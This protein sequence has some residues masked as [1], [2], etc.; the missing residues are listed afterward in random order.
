MQKNIFDIAPA[1]LHPTGVHFN[2]GKNKQSSSAA[3]S[4]GL[5]ECAQLQGIIRFLILMSCTLVVSMPRLRKKTTI[6]GLLFT[7]HYLDSYTTHGSKRAF[8][9][10]EKSI[11]SKIKYS[12]TC[13]YKDEYV[14][15]I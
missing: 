1:T 5:A 2:Y 8:Y 6:W 9:V 7:L 10:K 12:Y 14:I 13:V 3:D 15:I 4:M 11:E